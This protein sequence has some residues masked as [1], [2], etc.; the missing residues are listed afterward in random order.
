[1]NKYADADRQLAWSATLKRLEA[2][3]S[4]FVFEDIGS[5]AYNDAYK[6]FREHYNSC[7]QCGST[8]TE[9]RNYDP[10]WSDGDV[11]CKKCGTY[12]RGYDAG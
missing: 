11:V 12:V 7:P 4:A 10:H 5:D 1:M 9:V 8:D 6:M 2:K 3:L